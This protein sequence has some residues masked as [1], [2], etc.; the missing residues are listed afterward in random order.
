[1]AIKTNVVFLSPGES[2]VSD[3]P[4]GGG[5]NDNIFFQCTSTMKFKE[6]TLLYGR[7]NKVKAVRPKKNLKYGFLRCI[8]YLIESVLEGCWG[9][10][11]T[12]HVWEWSKV[13]LCTPQS[14]S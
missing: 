5:K 4:A 2:L 13:P 8:C 9:G 1:M 6:N 11:V 10:R 12:V 3:I 7:E 14:N